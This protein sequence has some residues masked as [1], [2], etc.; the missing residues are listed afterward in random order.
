[1]EDEDSNSEVAK[2]L[3]KMRGLGDKFS[4]LVIP[5]HHYGKAAS[6]G[7]RGGSVWRAGADVV[8]SVL[9]DRNDLT[10]EIDGPARAC[11]GGAPHPRRWQGKSVAVE[12]AGYQR[13]QLTLGIPGRPKIDASENSGAIL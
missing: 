3:K 12:A 6:T 11:F 4:G 7:M 1:M 9:C 2:V 13:I 10:G 5:I 8:L